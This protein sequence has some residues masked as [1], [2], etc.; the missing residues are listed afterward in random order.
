MVSDM[1]RGTVNAFL[2]CK[3]RLFWCERRGEIDVAVRRVQRL[4]K[5]VCWA[6]RRPHR[7]SQFW[8]SGFEVFKALKEDRV[9]QLTCYAA[10]LIL[11]GVERGQRSSAELLCSVAGSWRRIEV[12]SWIVMQHFWF[13]KA[14]KEDRGHQLNCYAAFLILEGIE[15]G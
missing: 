6:A 4:I 13:L 12:I 10:F 2:L 7:K 5:W 14:L 11:E 9:H 3:V 1:E 8:Q 15:R